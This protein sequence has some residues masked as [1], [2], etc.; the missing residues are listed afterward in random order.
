MRLISVK[1]LL[2]VIALGGVVQSWVVGVSDWW[3]KVL[4]GIL[5]KSYSRMLK[6]FY[7][8]LVCVCV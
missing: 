4:K 1:V 2:L 5:F 7:I 3:V 6:D 8:W